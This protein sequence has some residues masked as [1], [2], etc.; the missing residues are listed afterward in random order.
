ML[1]CNL[2]PV[3]LAEWLGFF[4]SATVVTRD[5][6]DTAEVSAHKVNSGD[7][8]APVVP[9]RIWTRNLSITSPALLPT[10]YPSPLSNTSQ[11][12]TCSIHLQPH[13]TAS[14]VHVR[15]PSQPYITDRCVHV[16][17]PLQSDYRQLWSSLLPQVIHNTWLHVCL[18]PSATKHNSCIYC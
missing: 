2:P 5:G 6:M 9:V 7:E 1:R 3:L 4:L 17:R 12:C 15:C 18:L 11:L 10:S 13:I 14:C 16:H 8:N